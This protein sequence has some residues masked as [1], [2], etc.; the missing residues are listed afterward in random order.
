MGGWHHQLNEHGFEQTQGDSEGQGGP[1]CCSP[2]DL[3]DSDMTEQPNNRVRAWLSQY[4]SG[5]NLA[6]TLDA[7]S[8]LSLALTPSSNLPSVHMQ[9]KR[10]LERFSLAEMA[11]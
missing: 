5:W 9:Y 3:K 1:A 2:W 11:G 6:L 7:D 10:S 4:K 8:E